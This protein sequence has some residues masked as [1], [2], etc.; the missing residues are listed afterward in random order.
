MIN[1]SGYTSYLT[2]SKLDQ[3]ITQHRT[4]VHAYLHA[5]EFVGIL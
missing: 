2:V 5:K 1:T 3:N 4:F